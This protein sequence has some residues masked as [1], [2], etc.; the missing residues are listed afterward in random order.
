MSVLPSFLEAP[1]QPNLC[2]IALNFLLTA[3]AA[4]S[5]PKK[6]VLFILQ[7]ITQNYTPT[8]NRHISFSLQQTLFFFFSGWFCQ[9]RFFFS[10]RNDEEV[11]VI[12]DVRSTLLSRFSVK[13]LY[14]MHLCRCDSTTVHMNYRARITKQP[15]QRGGNMFFLFTFLMLGRYKITK[16]INP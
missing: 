10:T 13:A 4:A 7:R 14:V 2:V 3:A 8:L 11:S 1:N 12:C 6:E 5:K 15:L 16:D 9:T